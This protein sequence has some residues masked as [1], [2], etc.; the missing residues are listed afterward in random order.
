MFFQEE[1]IMPVQVNT[2]LFCL[3]AYFS[4]VCS[5]LFYYTTLCL[6]GLSQSENK[7]NSWKLEWRVMDSDNNIITKYQLQIKMSFKLAMTTA[8]G[9]SVCIV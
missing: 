7:N 3:R 4:S 5:H 2:S 1:K 8:A 6:S 9:I